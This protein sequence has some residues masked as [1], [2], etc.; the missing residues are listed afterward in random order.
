MLPLFPSHS[1]QSTRSGA[2]EFIRI[3]VR[4]LRWMFDNRDPEDSRQLGGVYVGQWMRLSCQIRD[5]NYFTD[6]TTR[7]ICNQ[8]PVRWLPCHT[9]FQ[10]LFVGREAD[11]IS[12]V[13]PGDTTRAACRIAAT[14]DYGFRL[15]Q[16]EADQ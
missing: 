8:K 10:L 7:L 9:W 14:L 5:I 16:C 3:S 12:G 11:S 15:D 2:H 13:E 4:N 6:G 1:T